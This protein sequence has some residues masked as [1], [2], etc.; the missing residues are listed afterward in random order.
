[1]KKI[2][3]YIYVTFCYI[4]FLFADL[5]CSGYLAHNYSGLNVS[6]QIFKLNYIRNTGAAISIMQNSREA[7]I[8]LS[9]VAL[10]LLGVYIVR[11]IKS[12]KAIELFFIALLSAGISGNLHE[13]IVYGFVR[14]FFQLKFIN[15]PVFNISDIFITVG[16]IILVIMILLKKT[17]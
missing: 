4:L 9:V 10:T 3:K 16:V 7:L 8:I 5:N 11:H 15:F 13:R 17:K 12:I 2:S 6:N 14:D 1:M